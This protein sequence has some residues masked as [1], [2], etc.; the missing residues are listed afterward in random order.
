[1]IEK[2]LPDG[3]AW[4]EEFGDRA[5]A[6][7]VLFP[8][9]AAAMARAV[10]KR[11]R[12]FATGRSLAR[13]ALAG[14]GVAPASIPPGERGAPHWPPGIVGSITH[15]TGYRA[16]AV[17][18]ADR[19]RAIGIDA[20]PDRPLPDGVLDRVSLPGERAMLYDLGL[21]GLAAAGPRWDLL[22]FSAKE[23][24]YKAWFPLT[25][26]WLGFEDAELTFD[27]TT[28][29][30]ATGDPTTGDPATGGAAA[31]TFAARILAADL[32]A[33]DGAARDTGRGEP[34]PGVLR[35]RWLA[36]DGILLTAVSV[37]LRARPTP[38]G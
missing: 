18:R 25:G 8:D 6:D 32:S 26:R 29:D 11:R 19:V 10:D 36:S 37:P 38:R 4:A 21:G 9:E 20:E 35:G 12:E 31:G 7:A 24:V 34:V 3:V 5:D 13:E 22:L 2:V 17:V 16:A 1:V 28:G 27:P 33:T 15:C 14:L 23:S 30:P